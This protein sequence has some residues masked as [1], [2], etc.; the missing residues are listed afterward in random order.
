MNWEFL[1]SRAQA[2]V[3]ATQAALPD[4]LRDEALHVPVIFEAHPSPELLADGAD[5]DTLGFF[6]GP[7]RDLADTGSD[8]IPPHIL[9]YLENLWEF[10]DGEVAVYEEETRITYLHEL[11]HYLGLDEAELEARGLL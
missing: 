5:M 4:D 7:E 6:I 2:V 3:L 10:A 9:I 11:G 1:H 8:P